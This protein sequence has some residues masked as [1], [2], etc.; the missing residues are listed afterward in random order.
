MVANDTISQTP[1]NRQHFAVMSAKSRITAIEIMYALK[2]KPRVT[3]MRWPK[4]NWVTWASKKR[5]VGLTANKN[6]EFSPVTEI[7]FFFNQGPSWPSTTGP[8]TF[9]MTPVPITPCCRDISG[10]LSTVLSLSLGW[11]AWTWP[12]FVSA[13][14]GVL[15]DALLHW[16]ADESRCLS[17][18]IPT[19]RHPNDCEGKT[20][21][22]MRCRQLRLG[23]S[24][25]N[26]EWVTHAASNRLWSKNELRVSVPPHC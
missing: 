22:M 7:H 5:N 11:L 12:D 21:L 25:L 19:C 8:L 6:S 9:K 20:E 18:L 1:L 3:W 26:W 10:P 4:L 16:D 14:S 13:W 2:P 17:L 15:K 24:R 23:F